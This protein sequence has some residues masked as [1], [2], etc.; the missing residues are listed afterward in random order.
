MSPNSRGGKARTL[1]R[2]ETPEFCATWEAKRV[3]GETAGMT[4]S[5]NNYARAFGWGQAAGP[6]NTQ[7]LT[8]ADG[9]LTVT[10]NVRADEVQ[11]LLAQA[12]AE[13]ARLRDALEHVVRVM[14]PKVPPC[15]IG[16]EYEWNEALTTAREAVT[17]NVRA[18]GAP[19]GAD[20]L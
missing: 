10:V 13:I 7:G 17:P 18:K 15:C 3:A 6:G 20:T 2:H 16:C 8:M 9:N 4:G 11:A 19:D 1:G 5:R 14:G 12:D